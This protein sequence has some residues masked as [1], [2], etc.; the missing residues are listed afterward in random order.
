MTIHRAGSTL[1]TAGSAPT[2][3]ACWTTTAASRTR[4]PTSARPGS[5]PGR[6]TGTPSG[7]W[8]PPP[9][10][11]CWPRPPSSPNEPASTG[12]CDPP[13]VDIGPWCPPGGRQA[14]VPSGPTTAAT[15]ASY[16]RA[17]FSA[18][19]VIGLD[20]QADGGG[21]GGHGRHHHP[22]THQ[23]LRTGHRR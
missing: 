1:V 8:D 16:R 18:P 5:G 14:T 6:P 21:G 11:S 3:R 20:E 2:R 15:S 17:V 23:A 13:E 19:A 9:S 12:P 22:G 7:R 4:K 10:G